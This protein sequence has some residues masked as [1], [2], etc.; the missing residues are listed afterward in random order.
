MAITRN[1]RAQRQPTSL[2]PWIIVVIVS[3]G[4]LHV[5]GGLTLSAS[6]TPSAQ[7]SPIAIQGD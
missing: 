2:N 5:V 4:I 7:P 1:Y 6:N 3:F